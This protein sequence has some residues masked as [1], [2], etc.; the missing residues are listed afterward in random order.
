MSAP[1]TVRH[2]RRDDTLVA[3]PRQLADALVARSSK[4]SSARA[5][6]GLPT[7][8][9][10]SWRDPEEKD[11]TAFVAWAGDI[12]TTVSSSAALGAGA[13]IGSAPALRAPS[14]VT[15]AAAAMTPSASASTSQLPWIEIDSRLATSLHLA[16]GTRV[17]VKVAKSVPSASRVFL[18]PTSPD[19]W[20]I[21]LLNAA[22]VERTL[23]K[24]LAIV[25]PGQSGI[26]LVLPPPIN[27]TVHVTV[28]R[29]EPETSTCAYLVEG[30][31][32]AIEPKMRARDA[33]KKTPVP[34]LLRLV[35]TSSP[36]ATVV[37]Q[38]ETIGVHPDDWAVLTDHLDAE[39]HDSHVT[40]TIQLLVPPLVTPL[41]ENRQQGPTDSDSKQAQPPI[42]IHLAV[43]ANATR[44]TL[45]VPTTAS[46]TLAAISRSLSSLHA[47]I[48]GAGIEYHGLG[49]TVKCL[50]P[51]PPSADSPDKRRLR[52]ASISSSPDPPPATTTALS[53]PALLPSH[54]IARLPVHLSRIQ[55][56]FAAYTHTRLPFT[57]AG[58][59]GSGKSLVARA[60]LASLSP[61]ITRIY[62]SLDTFLAPHASDRQLALLADLAK[63]LAAVRP[64]ALVLDALD[65]VVGQGE[66]QPEA[67]GE[68]DKAGAVARALV[69]ELGPIVEKGG[70]MCC[71]CVRSPDGVHRVMK[72]AR[73]VVEDRADK[74]N[75]RAV[76]LGQGGKEERQDI[77][78]A[79]LASPH[80]QADFDS[81]NLDALAKQAD[82]YTALDLAHVVARAQ[83]AA[84]TDPESLTV[85][86]AH[87]QSA[88]DA[89]TP[90]T[91]SGLTQDADEG[92]PAP[93]LGSIGGLAAAKHAL[94]STLLYP[95]LYPDLFSSLPL[96]PRQGLLLYGHPGCGKTHLLTTFARAHHLRLLAVKGPE[97]L[98]KY[99]GASEAAVRNLFARARAAAPCVVFL[100]E[101]DALAPRRGSDNSGVT[102]RVV[103]QLL[104]E[105]DGAEGLG[106]GVFV[107]GATSRPDLVDP[108]LCRPGRLDKAVL[109]GLPDVAERRLILEAVAQGVSMEIADDGID[110]EGVWEWVAKQTEGFSGA[111]LQ[112]IV[113]NASLEGVEGQVQVDDDGNVLDVHGETEAE[114]TGAA[115][116]VQVTF[117]AEAGDM[118]ARTIAGY[119]NFDGDVES[120][121][122]TARTDA[123]ASAPK[124]SLA[125]LQKA[126]AATRPSV[127]PQLR[128]KLDR[129]YHV[130]S[131][132]EVEVPKQQKLV[133]K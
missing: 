119:L 61:L 53:P 68:E 20:D 92:K 106:K 126:L 111:D 36:G 80:I 125:H 109:C 30:A 16:N 88:L 86:H 25:L 129:I 5:I 3:V 1:L 62:I 41:L 37:G 35:V 113:Y 65:S 73:W 63:T 64:A 103:N 131:N 127:S 91:V 13:G 50:V 11:A 17:K 34:K 118:D 81:I 8:L 98:D 72:E 52:R 40:A 112:A 55:S 90:A 128:S 60:W 71:V 27:T 21:L 45:L 56:Y 22:V 18:S 96:R 77:L 38:V 82:G 43:S 19:D 102:D 94:T 57:L 23:L 110:E 133:L 105:M 33:R 107:V 10:L 104:T 132:G 49:W 76:V 89:Y 59:S 115:G 6:A 122:E 31:E 28:Q 51:P 67:G 29:I 99:I 12:A 66:T 117:R 2:V 79:L 32:V 46:A 15:A 70:V 124:I 75:P 97:L 93:T 14:T 26:P 54:P 83:H 120:P 121:G 24:S 48:H 44:G 85:T 42:R 4:P 39:Q 9:Q 130:F 114:A 69:K 101:L 58:P 74:V 123:K 95:T 100:D 116:V 84:L 87:M 108:A 47:T 78:E 7:V